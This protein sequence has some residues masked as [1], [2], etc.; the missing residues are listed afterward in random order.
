MSVTVSFIILMLIFSKSLKKRIYLDAEL[1][2]TN[3]PLLIKNEGIFRNHFQN[4]LSGDDRN[5]AIKQVEFSDD[6]SVAIRAKMSTESLQTDETQARNLLMQSIV[7]NSLNDRS[8]NFILGP[9]LDSVTTIANA[10]DAQAY[11]YLV[12][13]ASQLR[14]SRA[15]YFEQIEH[16]I[17]FG[18][19]SP[20]THFSKLRKYL[21]YFN[22]ENHQNIEVFYKKI[23]DLYH[24]PFNNETYF[25][26]YFKWK[27]V[28]VKINSINDAFDKNSKRSIYKLVFLAVGIGCSILGLMILSKSLLQIK[29]L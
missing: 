28:E 10:I 26:H 27:N 6:E 20:S 4:I 5:V 13:I 23:Q 2:F 29:N 25:R 3:V 21:I 14:S 17:L 8:F 18:N 9:S 12:E 16:M 11:S 1:S 7:A 15:T 19:E 22:L 24:T